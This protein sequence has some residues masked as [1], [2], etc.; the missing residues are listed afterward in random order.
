[1]RH[2]YYLMSNQRLSSLLRQLR[3]SRLELSCEFGH[4]NCGCSNVRC[5]NGFAACAQAVTD[6]IKRRETRDANLIPFAAH[7]A[8]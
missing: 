5:M 6:E 3:R 4:P 7:V 1:M 2:N 8:S